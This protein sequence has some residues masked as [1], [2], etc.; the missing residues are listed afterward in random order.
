V[1]V[2]SSIFA[3]L[4]QSELFQSDST[5]RAWREI[6]SAPEFWAKLNLDMSFSQVP[7]LSQPSSVRGYSVKKLACSG[8]IVSQVLSQ[9][10]FSTCRTLDLSG[11]QFH[12]EDWQIVQKSMVS[13]MTNIE[14]LNLRRIL[15]FYPYGYQI[16]VQLSRYSKV[17]CSRLRSLTYTHLK[18]YDFNNSVYRRA[19]FE[20]LV[21]LSLD[22]GPNSNSP[23]DHGFDFDLPSLL[24]L[25][26]ENNVVLT[27]YGLVYLFQKCPALRT[28]TLKNW[29]NWSIH[30]DGLLL[31][32]E[33]CP[34]GLELIVLDDASKPPTEF[35]DTFWDLVRAHRKM[36]GY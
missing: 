6:I 34:T 18:K 32:V 36:R 5:C 10:R 19:A 26:I 20:N 13:S 29:Y 3:F 31:L 14:H 8:I 17:F 35:M 25:R 9:P 11:N 15:L 21:S 33:N 1:E 16:E 30:E 22:G 24:H 4:T 7:N 27:D 28:L 2:A 23:D 12:H